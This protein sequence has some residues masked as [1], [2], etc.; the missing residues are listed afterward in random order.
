MAYQV[1]T[2]SRIG[3]LAAYVGVLG[4]ALVLGYLVKTGVIPTTLW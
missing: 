2:K 3:A 4:T 1:D